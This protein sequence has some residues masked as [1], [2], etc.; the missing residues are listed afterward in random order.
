MQVS[1]PDRHS[2]PLENVSADLRPPLKNRH[3]GL[4]F[5][6]AFAVAEHV[7]GTT[8]KLFM[9]MDIDALARL[10]AS[11]DTSGWFRLS[12]RFTAERSIGLYENCWDATVRPPFLSRR[13]PP[14]VVN[15]RRLPRRISPLT[16][17]GWKWPQA[18]YRKDGKIVDGYI[19]HRQYSGESTWNWMILRKNEVIREMRKGIMGAREAARTI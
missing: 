1:R 9:L 18:W 19:L 2:I 5:L 17:I 11:M 3:A 7:C 16:R 14:V 15:A 12:A 13:R 10:C 4:A 8:A 6:F